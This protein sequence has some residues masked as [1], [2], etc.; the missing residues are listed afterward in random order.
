MLG[1]VLDRDAHDIL[2]LSL[3]AGL[4]FSVTAGNVIRLVPALTI[5]EAEADELVKRITPVIRSFLAQP[6]I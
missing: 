2:E 3:K 6:K 5:T 1:I 4:T